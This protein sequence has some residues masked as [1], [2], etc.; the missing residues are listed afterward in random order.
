MGG[1]PVEVSSQNTTFRET[2]VVAG[3]LGII[4]VIAGEPWYVLTLPRQFFWFNQTAG[5]VAGSVLVEWAIRDSATAGVPEWL[6]LANIPLIVGGLTPVL[7]NVTTGAV[8]LRFT[9]QA[10]NGDTVELACSSFV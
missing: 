5:A 9:V 6:Q 2:I 10:R 8:W 1:F 4:S 7:T 3:G